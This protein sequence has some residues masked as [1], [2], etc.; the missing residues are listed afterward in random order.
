MIILCGAL[1]PLPRSCG[2][3][4][5]RLLP[6]WCNRNYQNTKIRTWGV[7]G[8]RSAEH[9]GP[10]HWQGSIDDPSAL[11]RSP[12]ES[13]LVWLSPRPRRAGCAGG[14]LTSSEGTGLVGLGRTGSPE[15]VRKC[16]NMPSEKRMLGASLAE[17]DHGPYRRAVVRRRQ[18]RATT[19][20]ASF[21]V[22]VQHLCRQPN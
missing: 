18:K 22:F 6:A 16:H 1:E 7:P 9:R 19:R 5:G 13:A 3:F 20:L 17:A 11:D 2:E 14:S 21:P 4:E 8:D 15:R 12:V 10:H